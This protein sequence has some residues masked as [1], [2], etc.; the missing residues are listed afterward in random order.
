VANQTNLLAMNAAIEAAHAGE[1]GKGFAVVAGE[2]RKLA[3]A[4][5]AQAKSSDATL[6]AVR[7][8]IQEIVS[9]SAL[10]ESSCI[11]T[12]SLITEINNVSTQIK[13]AVS[14][15]S[16]GSSQILESLFEINKI[17][18]QVR[19]GAEKIK[20]ETDDSLDAVNKV[21]DMSSQMNEK[22][23]GIV[24]KAEE[25][26]ETSRQANEMVEQNN[27][28]LG[29]LQTAIANFTIRK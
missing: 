1:T 6:S 19:T 24:G 14:E 17:T 8:R 22:L 16:S 12:N 13:N 15:Q 29:S 7:G 11:S 26:S 20:L 4:S 25:V 21:A 18:E 27:Q 28:G 5:T 10:I 3:E 9:E 2:I 23:A